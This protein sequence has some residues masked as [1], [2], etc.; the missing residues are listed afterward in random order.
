MTKN[1]NK[2]YLTLNISYKKHYNDMLCNIATLCMLVVVTP[3]V[4][5]LVKFV[6]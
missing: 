3:I 1:Y 6:G 4:I 5:S 2:Q